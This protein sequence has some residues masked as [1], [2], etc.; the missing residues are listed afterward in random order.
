MRDEF[1]EEV[2]RIVAQRVG[3]HCSKPDCCADTSGPQIDPSKALNV[4]VAAHVTAA[5]PGG[6]RYNLMLSPDERTHPSN[7][8]WLCQTCAKLI[9]ND[10]ARFPVTLLLQWK[11]DAE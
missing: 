4:G 11:T 5:S 2:K 8:I 10:A 3:S 1:S 9:D 6:A 7:A